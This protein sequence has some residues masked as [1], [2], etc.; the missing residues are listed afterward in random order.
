MLPAEV[1]QPPLVNFLTQIILTTT[2]GCQDVVLPVA[3]PGSTE[4]RCPH[5][6]SN[7]TP[8]QERQ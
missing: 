2:M 3:N 7:S 5:R 6:D 8:S 4:I 1:Y